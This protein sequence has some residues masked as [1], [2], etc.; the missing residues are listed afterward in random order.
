MNSQWTIRH[1]YGAWAAEHLY[2]F[3]VWALTK[4]ELLAC[5]GLKETS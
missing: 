3:T 5:L 4:E 1:M 2:G